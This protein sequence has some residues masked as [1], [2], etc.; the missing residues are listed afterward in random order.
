MAP[1]SDFFVITAEQNLGNRK[2]P[3]IGRAGKLRT[4]EQACRETFV[5]AGG[6]VT[7]DAW[8]EPCDR[9]DDERGRKLAAT[10]NKIADGCFFVNQILSNPFVHSFIS[11]TDEQEFVQRAP[12]PGSS[13]IEQTAL[14]RH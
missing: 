9:V 5:F 11:A 8:E 1:F 14:R 2:P 6:L 13:L 4:I 3:E 10:H 7:E 12:A